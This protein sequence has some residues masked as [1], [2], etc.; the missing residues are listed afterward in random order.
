MCISGLEE[1]VNPT[2]EQ[3]IKFLKSHTHSLLCKMSLQATLVAITGLE[4]ILLNSIAT[5]EGSTLVTYTNVHMHMQDILNTDS[6]V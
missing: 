2:V 6:I 5:V 4:T 1:L 3:Y